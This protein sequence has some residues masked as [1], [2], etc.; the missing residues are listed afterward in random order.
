MI[1]QTDIWIKLWA[2][3]PQDM[4]RTFLSYT[5][6]ASKGVLVPFT[7]VFAW[8]EYSWGRV[9]LYFNFFLHGD[10]AL[11][12][13][14]SKKYKDFFNTMLAKM[15]YLTSAVH[16]LCKS[17]ILLTA[18][19]CSEVKMLYITIHFYICVQIW[20]KSNDSN[21]KR[22]WLEMKHRQIL[23]FDHKGWH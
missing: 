12:S 18:V 17:H 9:L 16:E 13:K 21:V 7:G 1:S 15:W 6:I 20:C 5:K 4:D 3:F 14:T 2:N 23:M 11:L 8:S 19:K 22:G 10:L